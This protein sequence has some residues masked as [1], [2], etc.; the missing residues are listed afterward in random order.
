MVGT[1]TSIQPIVCGPI[2]V[3]SVGFLLENPDAAIIWRGPV[4]IGV[5]QQFLDNVEWGEL[6]SLV[7]DCPPG[8]GDEPLTVCQSIGQN[9]GAVIVT[10]PQQIAAADVARSISFCGDVGL[11]VWGLVENMSGFVC[12]HCGQVTDIFGSGAGESLANKFGIPFAGKIPLD[13]SVCANGDKGL[14]MAGKFVAEAIESVVAN[15]LQTAG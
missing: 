9:A 14:P 11:P 15:I 6:D 12:P 1:G 2:K 8:T 7:V 4:K 13:A 3:A 5:I 10:T